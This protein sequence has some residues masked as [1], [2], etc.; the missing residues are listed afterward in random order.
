M[1]KNK[2]MELHKLGASYTT[3]EIV[4]G[5]INMDVDCFNGDISL[6]NVARV[7]RNTLKKLVE[8]LYSNLP[9]SHIEELQVEEVV[10]RSYEISNED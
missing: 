9:I 5:I 6:E 10:K 8:E 1:K 2:L 7:S 3:L 4:E